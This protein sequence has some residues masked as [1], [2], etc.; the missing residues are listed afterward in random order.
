MYERILVALDGSPAAE[1]VL[2]HAE[3]LA[4]AFGSHITLLHATLSAEMILAQAG[5]GDASV[6]EIPPAL[7]PQP[8]L[9]ADHQTAT[10]YLERVSAQLKQRGLQVEAETPEGAAN[11]VI[12]ERA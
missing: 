5:A 11:T 10:S 4:S 12:V 6:G 2:P 1:H 9:E 3:A 7:D 8:V